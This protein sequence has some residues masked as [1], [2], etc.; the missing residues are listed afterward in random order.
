MENCII[1]RL[2]FFDFRR[3]NMSIICITSAAPR[4]PPKPDLK[5]KREI[6]F[7]PW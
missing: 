4:N 5:Q 7:S 3:L 2:I 1:L 6:E